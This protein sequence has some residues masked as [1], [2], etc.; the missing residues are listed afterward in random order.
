MQTRKNA[1]TDGYTVAE[2]EK[3][4]SLEHEEFGSIVV[5]VE[6]AIAALVCEIPPDW[7][8]MQITQKVYESREMLLSATMADGTSVKE[9]QEA[10]KLQTLLISFFDS[11]FSTG[12]RA[13]SKMGKKTVNNA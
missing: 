5:D 1:L 4:W 3:I 2:T 13:D 8:V 11:L 12:E 9:Y 6:E 10:L 7:N